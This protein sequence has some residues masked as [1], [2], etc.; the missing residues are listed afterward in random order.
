M[1]KDFVVTAYIVKDGKV[2]LVH[3]RKLG[4]WLP[5]GGHIDE[6]ETPDEAILREAKEEAGLE[7]EIA[8]RKYETGTRKGVVEMLL[9]PHH[10]QLEEIDGKHQH[11]DMVYFAKSKSG[12]VVL[13]KDE[14][15]EIRWFSPEDLD[16]GTVPPTTKHFARQAIRELKG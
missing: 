2:L 6:G 14:H 11:I 1:R 15:D 7:I 12:R 13:K 5:V 9:T 3:H 4:M 10:I 16:S 8:G